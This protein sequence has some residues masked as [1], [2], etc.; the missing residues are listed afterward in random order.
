MVPK[1][2]Q[3]CAPSGVAREAPCD[4]HACRL[5]PLRPAPLRPCLPQPSLAGPPC[6]DQPPRGPATVQH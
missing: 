2:G 3:C 4:Q 1:Q 5:G 6:R